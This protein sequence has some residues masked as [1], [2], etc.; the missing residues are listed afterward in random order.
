MTDNIT[1]RRAAEY[2][3]VALDRLLYCEKSCNCFGRDAITA[4]AAALAQPEHIH[5][6]G[7]DCQKP[8]CVN[9][10]REISEAVEAERE[11]ILAVIEAYKV[12]VGNSAA[13]EMACEWTMD[14]LRDLRDAIRA[15]GSK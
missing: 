2:A 7:P 11:A 13:G 10:R 15:R 8:L 14:A 9:R 5:S 1:L 12:P 3:R 6:C 4:L